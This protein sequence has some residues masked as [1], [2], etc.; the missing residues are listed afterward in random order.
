MTLSVTK[1]Q[2]PN[3]VHW[4]DFINGDAIERLPEVSSPKKLLQ[5][6]SEL[7]D[8][9]AAEEFDA[10]DILSCLLERERL[11][12]TA[13]GNGIALPHARVEGLQEPRIAIIQLENGIDMAAADNKP[14]DLVIG[15]AIPIEC[16]ELHLKLLASISRNLSDSSQADS[17]RNQP[18]TK[19]ML[20]LIRSWV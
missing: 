20:Q 5:E 12:S 7:L 1:E 13:L 10:D 17:L 16:T 9:P 11:G 18:D 6:L 14:V 8:I 19:A 15:L 4:G 2:C 3:D